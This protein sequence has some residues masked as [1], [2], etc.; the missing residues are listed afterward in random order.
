MKV[1]R[2]ISSY[3]LFVGV[4]GLSIV[5]GVVAYQIYSASIKSQTTLEQTT[6][7]KPLDGVINQSTIDSLRSRTVYSDAEMELTLLATPTPQPEASQSGEQAES[8]E[9]ATIQ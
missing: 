6:A 3:V 2:T 1:T 8:T 9:S 7:I 4:M 5:G